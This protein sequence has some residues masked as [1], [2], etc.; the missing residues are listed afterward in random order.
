MSKL[1]IL[2]IFLFTNFILL[3]QVEEMV[4][5][6]LAAKPDSTIIDVMPNGNKFVPHFTLEGEDLVSIATSYGVPYWAVE[7]FNPGLTEQNVTPG[8]WIKIPLQKHRVYKYITEL[9]ALDTLQKVYYKVKKGETLYGIAKRNFET[10]IHLIQAYNYL[11]N[12]E[13]SVG[14]LLHVAYIPRFDWGPILSFEEYDPIVEDET[15]Q[16]EFVA[17][18]PDHKLLDER[19]AATISAKIG[20]DASL[21]ALHR[22]AA[23]G[24]VI[25]I[26][27]PDTGFTVHTRVLGKI[28]PTQYQK[29]IKVV[30]SP[31]VA[32]LLGGINKEFFVTLQYHK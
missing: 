21:F 22:T 19:G 9:S 27:N 14:Q 18:G 25:K 7:K 28:P 29:H 12:N 1:Y 30:V 13:I 2:G 20:D 32:E 6:P 26:S 31:K 15:L 8:V 11:E 4:A 10:E 3:A 24:S 16:N 17:K 23:K 5:P